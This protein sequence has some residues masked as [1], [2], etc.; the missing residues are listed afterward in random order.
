MYCFTQLVSACTARSRKKDGERKGSRK[1][2][3]RLRRRDEEG[4]GSR[5]GIWMEKW[6]HIRGGV[7]G[8]RQVAGLG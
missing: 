6:E 1:D 4:R 2:E 8:G 3:G 5:G 7:T